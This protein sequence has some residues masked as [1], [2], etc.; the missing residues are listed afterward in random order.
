MTQPT[1]SP[2]LLIPGPTPVPQPVLEALARPTEA[3][4]SPT[5]A[6]A[7][8]T[9]QR[10]ILEAVGAEAGE[11]PLALV[12]AGSGTLGLEAALVNL[13][14]PGDT[15]LVV[16]HGFFG[17]RYAELGRTLGAEVVEASCPWGEQVPPDQ[18][19]RALTESGARVMTVT[20]VDTAT[21]VVAPIAAYAE[22]ARRHE[23]LMV[24]D[25]VAGVGGMPVEMGRLGIDVVVT[26]SQKALGA[27]PG[28]AILALSERALEH[29]RRLGRSGSYFLD[30]LRWEGPMRDPVARYFATLPTNLVIAAG[31]ALQ[32][33]VAEG[34]QARFR[35][36]HRMGIA[37]RRGLRAIGL[38]PI[39]TEEICSD[40]VSAFG[41]PSGVAPAQLRLE[42]AKHGVSIAGGIGAWSDSAGRVGHMGAAGLPELMEGMAALESA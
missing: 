8:R 40:T 18:V 42:V 3:H 12:L 22:I 14:R 34:W 37:M 29:R 7:L 21:G 17:D 9:A 2:L 25:S 23:A 26:A 27:P 24:L 10:G 20:H 31:A 41:L 11:G 30:W 1:T 15:L 28:L 5:T 16:N 36:H 32:L 35:R 13:I 38:P 33:A 4:S 6:A 39:A 19:E